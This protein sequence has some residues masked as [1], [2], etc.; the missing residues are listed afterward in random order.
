M[1]PLSGLFQNWTAGATGVWTGV[2]ML[3]AY[4]L[5]QMRL[6]RKL[7][8]DDRIARREGYEKQVQMLTAENR[9]LGEDQRSLREEYDNYRRLCKLE[10]DQLRAMVMALEREVEGLKRQRAVDTIHEARGKRGTQQ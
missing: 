8:A 9:L 6:D 7:S 2:L 4:I 10:T 5:N 1:P 3:A